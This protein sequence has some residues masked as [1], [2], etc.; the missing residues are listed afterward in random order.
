[1]LVSTS[2]NSIPFLSSSDST[3][4]QMSAKQLAQT[5][6]SLGCELP[7]VIGKDYPYLSHTCNSFKKI[8][9]GDGEVLYSNKDILVIGFID[10][11]DISKIET[12]NIPRYK[13][14]A[15]MFAT[16]IRNRLYSGSFKKGDVIYEYDSFADNVPCYGYNT[17]V[18]YF[19][20]FG[21]NFE[22]SIV[23]SESLAKRTTSTKLK[24]I[25]I[26]I[27]KNSIYKFIYPNS[28]YG[29]LP[30]IGQTINKKIIVSQINDKSININDYL[31][32]DDVDYSLNSV[33]CK[34]ENATIDNIKIHR[35]D[36]FKFNLLD[37]K[38]DE[39]ITRMRQDYATKVKQ[40]SVDMT[41]SVGES[42]TRSILTTNYIMQSAKA[43]NISKDELIYVIE[44][45]LVK[46]Q[47]T[48]VGDKLANRF[49]NKGIV[50][51][52]MP[53]KLMPVNLNTGE[54]VDIILGTLGV[55]SRMNFAQIN[56]CIIAKAIQKVQKEILNDNSLLK[57]NLLKLSNL[58]T[59]LGD[60]DYAAEILD[61][62]NNCDSIK[63]EFINSVKKNG[64]YFEAPSFTN[65][66]IKGLKD[67]VEETFNL[68]MSDSIKIPKETFEYIK[69]KLN[70]SLPL[71]TEDLVYPKIFNSSI[72]MLKLMQLANTKLTARDFGSYSSNR[73]PSKDKVGISTGSRL[74]GINNSVP[75]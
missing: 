49:A 65:V 62:H 20:W 73:Q 5:V 54:R 45:D 53:D 35:V 29:F 51:L 44:L 3:R 36:G 25:N 63:N 2:L 6:T 7:F 75:H 8:A 71:P 31:D 46:K 23:I 68:T 9:E 43:S 13:E 47:S 4:L 58:A 15:N 16:T 40:Y 59:K 52:I 21:Y 72:Y 48:V 26:F 37:K 32:N 56:E 69:E 33:V 42:L 22:D 34:L 27:Y 30:E 74:G 1:M 17:N 66:N 18:I 67:F 11:Q 57:P 28:K 55:Y 38:L 64:L 19:P 24:K 14:T 70:I 50:N 10:D 39:C 41:N 61:L 60:D 12:Y